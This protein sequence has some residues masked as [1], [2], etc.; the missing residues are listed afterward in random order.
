M[1]REKRSSNSLSSFLKTLRIGRCSFGNQFT[2]HSSTDRFA[3]IFFPQDILHIQ[4]TQLILLCNVFVMTSYG[5]I[6][7]RGAGIS[8]GQPSP[9]PRQPH[10]HQ[11][12]GTRREISEDLWHPEIRLHPGADSA[13]T[14]TKHRVRPH[15]SRSCGNIDIDSYVLLES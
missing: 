13:E 8:I 9:V 15:V 14:S 7:C 12:E 3:T 5:T 1:L 11:S 6:I 2:F 4:K 10:G